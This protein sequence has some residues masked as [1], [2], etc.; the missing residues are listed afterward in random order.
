MSKDE[1]VTLARKSA[2]ELKY[3]RQKAKRLEEH[4]KNMTS[5]GPK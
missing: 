3:L 2:K 5:V 4:R 1:L